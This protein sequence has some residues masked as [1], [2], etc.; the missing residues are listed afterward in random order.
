MGKVL[1][2]DDDPDFVE[3]V[4]TILLADGHEIS[5]AANGDQALKRMREDRPDVILLDMMMSYVLDGLDVTRKMWQDPKLRKIPVIMVT[6]LTATREAAVFP[7]DEH[8]S[9]DDWISKPVRPS[10]LRKRVNELLTAG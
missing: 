10:D 7:S 1:V 2:V 4:R 5:T 6:S 3:I 9:I 8:M